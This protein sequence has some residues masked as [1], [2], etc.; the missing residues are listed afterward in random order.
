[1]NNV[2]NQFEHRSVS[3]TLLLCN[4]F[5]GLHK[6]SCTDST[7]LLIAIDFSYIEKYRISL[8]S[9]IYATTATLISFESSAKALHSTH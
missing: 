5:R 9:R 2:N 8:L 6:S 3:L 1:M 7:T 4:F